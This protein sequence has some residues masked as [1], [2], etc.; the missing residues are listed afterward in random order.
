MNLGGL[1]CGR[2]GTPLA[3]A[4]LNTPDLVPC[5]SCGTAIRAIVFPSLLR[6]F[7]PGES[8]QTLVLDTQASCFYHAQKT[9][10][11]ACESCGRFLCALCDVELHGKHFCPAC[12]ESGKRKGRLAFLEDRRMLYDEL[13]L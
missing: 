8:A 3:V 13:A 7:T 1:N 11:V 4:A 5:V 10:V 12:L 9:A 2:C 6:K